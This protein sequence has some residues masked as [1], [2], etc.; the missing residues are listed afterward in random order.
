[1]NFT[2][3]YDAHVASQSR[4]SHIWRLIERGETARVRSRD[5]RAIRLPWVYTLWALKGHRRLITRMRGKA[6]GK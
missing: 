5:A 2:K 6:D 3:V 1:M 4:A